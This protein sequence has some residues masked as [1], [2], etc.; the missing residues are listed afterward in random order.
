MHAKPRLPGAQQTLLAVEQRGGAGLLSPSAWGDIPGVREHFPDENRL[1]ATL[2]QRWLHTLATEVEHVLETGAGDLVAD[3]RLAYR[4]AVARHHGLR[5]IL[6]ANGGH[7]SV[8]AG[9]RREH[10]LLCRAAGVGNAE[11]LVCRADEV[12][13]RPRRRGCMERLAQLMRRQGLPTDV[14]VGRTPVEGSLPA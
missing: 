13:V 3:V 4:R 12:T 7:P 11:Q 8:A 5:R 10:Q 1:L 2:Q 6:D 14:Q 9:R